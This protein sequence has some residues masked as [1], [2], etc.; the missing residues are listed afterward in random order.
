M[1]TLS[2]WCTGATFF[3]THL[4]YRLKWTLGVCKAHERRPHALLRPTTTQSVGGCDICWAKARHECLLETECRRP[5]KPARTALV[6]THERGERVL[7][8]Y[9]NAMI[10]YAG[11]HGHLWPLGRAPAIGP[12]Q[13]REGMCAFPSASPATMQDSKKLRPESRPPA[14][15]AVRAP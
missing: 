10:A 9:Y 2:E 3:H 5:P 12:W 11:R 14:R 4:R 7:I 8:C 13:L 1:C 15:F 6:W